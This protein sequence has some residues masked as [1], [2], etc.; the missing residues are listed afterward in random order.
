MLL[1][2]KI[3]ANGVQSYKKISIQGTYQ[4]DNVRNNCPNLTVDK[5]YMKD[6]SV[7]RLLK[8]TWVKQYE[9]N[10]DF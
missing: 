5:R 7:N 3:S 10:D 8:T 9:S 2:K 6:V 4:P 1:L